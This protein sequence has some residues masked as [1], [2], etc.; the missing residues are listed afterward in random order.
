MV[1]LTP[2]CLF[3]MILSDQTNRIRS[4]TAICSSI[5][6]WVILSQ[7][8]CSLAKLQSRSISTR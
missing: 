4:I 1:D 5:I 3:R 8:R 7:L 6:F 2:F